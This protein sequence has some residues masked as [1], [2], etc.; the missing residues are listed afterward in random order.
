MGQPWNDFYKPVRIFKPLLIIQA[1]RRPMISHF[2]CSTKIWEHPRMFAAF[3]RLSPPIFTTSS[4]STISPRYSVLYM[5]WIHHTPNRWI[6]FHIH[7]FSFDYSNDLSPS[8]LWFCYLSIWSLR[9]IERD[10][11]RG[12]LRYGGCVKTGPGPDTLA[13]WDHFTGPKSPHLIRSPSKCEWD[14]YPRRT[15]DGC[16]SARSS[17]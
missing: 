14:T 11:R 6:L 10:E 16:Q 3:I 9:Y 17:C 8:H 5:T 7:I 1:C 13:C 15:R 12:V 4:S 2:S